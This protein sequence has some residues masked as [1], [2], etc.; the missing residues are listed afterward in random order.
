[1]R[2]IHLLLLL[3]VCVVA[4]VAFGDV[5]L[6]LRDGRVLDGIDVVRKQNQYMLEISPDEIMSIPV[7]LSM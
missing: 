4:G 7:E 3:A 1:M 6:V 2:R 5:Q